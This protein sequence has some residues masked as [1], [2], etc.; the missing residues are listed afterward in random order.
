MSLF[1]IVIEL[2]KV[3]WLID[4]KKRSSTT[5]VIGDYVGVLQITIHRETN[6]LVFLYDGIGFMA[7]FVQIL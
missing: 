6:Q 3:P 7:R 5:W 2:F 4:C 1:S